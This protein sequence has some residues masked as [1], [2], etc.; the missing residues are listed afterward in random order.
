MTRRW[1]RRSA[2]TS[3]EADGPASWPVRYPSDVAGG[4][5]AGGVLAEGDP[6]EQALAGA[7]DGGYL[8]GDVVAQPA[9]HPFLFDPQQRLHDVRVVARRP[10]RCPGWP[11]R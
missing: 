5:G 7:L 10:C 11:A 1:R 9:D 2:S 6:D 8:G 3:G 4:P